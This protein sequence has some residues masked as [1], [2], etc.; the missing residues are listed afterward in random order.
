MNEAPDGEREPAG[1]VRLPWPVVGAGLFVLLVGLLGFGLFAN[2]NLRPQAAAAPTPATAV[3][4]LT[5]TPTVARVIADAPT[6]T[7]I[8]LTPT[9]VSRPT[10]S[11]GQTTGSASEPPSVETPSALP[12]VDPSLVPDISRAYE[13]YWHIRAQALLDL[14]K[15]HLTEAM[16]GDHLASTAQLID[17][18]RTENRAI[19][20]DVDHDYRVV[21]ATG[22][23]AQVFD[24]YLSNSFYVDPSTEDA[25]TQPASD[26]LKVF[27]KMVKLNGE[28]K[29]VDSVRA[30]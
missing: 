22:G 23:A 29:V 24:D 25:I 4:P 19:K 2:R 11:P 6:A 7:P 12:S 15:E 16:G 5:L 10:T 30:D 18:L 17:E 1:Y 27:Y 3:A 9:P 28:W 14:D 20:T 13:K 8:A 26:E 21:E